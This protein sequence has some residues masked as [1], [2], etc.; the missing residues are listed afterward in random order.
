MPKKK[1]PVRKA[2][3]QRPLKAENSGSEWGS[4]DSDWESS[5]DEE[6]IIKKRKS[7]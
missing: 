4:D 2:K 1:A 5:G 3:K 6:K 7:E